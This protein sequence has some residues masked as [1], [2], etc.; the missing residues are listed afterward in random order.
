MRSL[1]I[2]KRKV[3][4]RD[5]TDQLHIR[6]RKDRNGRKTIAPFINGYNVTD[7]PM[8]LWVPEVQ[9]AIIHAY[10]LGRLNAIAQIT[11]S[12]PTTTVA[13]KEWVEDKTGY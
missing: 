4:G 1:H 5:V 13:A 2:L 9:R 3:R 8:R 10:E 7:L 12:L 11:D 6:Y